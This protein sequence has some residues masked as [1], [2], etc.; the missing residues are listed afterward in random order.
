MKLKLPVMALGVLTAGIMAAQT[1][2]APQAPEAAQTQPR[3]HR[4]EAGNWQD[5]AV[6][7]MTM[8]L[9]LSA[10]QQAQVKTIFKDSR[11]QNKALRAKFRE[12]RMALD[13][14]VKADSEQQIDRITRE[15]AKLNS[16]IAANRLKAVAKVYAIL[17]PDQKAKFDKGFD[18]RMGVEPSTGA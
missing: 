2:A 1:P 8:R 15:N 4:K 3:H 11:E 14:A 7:R 13:A 12:E 18:R 17:T 9:S 5:R 16:E 10:D 6:K